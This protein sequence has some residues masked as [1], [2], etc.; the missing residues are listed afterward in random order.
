MK[1]LIIVATF[2][3]GLL[4]TSV[5]ATD[6]SI[7]GNV[8]ETL[9]GSDNY[10]LENKP[11]PSGPTGQTNTAGTLDFL[12]RTLTTN[13]F[14]D[15][16]YSY[17]KYFGPGAADTFPTW[18][19]PAHVNFNV[20]HTEKLTTY[21]AGASWTRSDA[22]VTELAQT[23]RTSTI[24]GSVSTYSANAAINHDLNRV[25]SLSWTAVASRTSFTDPTAFPFKDVTTVAAWN[26]ALSP[27]TKLSAFVS[28]DWFSEDDPAQS[29]RLF[30]KAMSTLS[31]SL[32]P[33]LTFNGRVGWGFV[34]SYQT[35][36][37]AIPSIPVGTVSFVPQVGAA[38]SILADIA[39]TYRLLKTTSVS[40]TAAEAI[41]P[42]FNGQLQKTDQIGL[43]LS[44]DVN[45]LS[46]LVLSASFSFIPATTGSSTFGAQSSA[47]DFFSASI[48]YGYQLAREWRT[49][50]SYTYRQRNDDTGIARSSLI[51]F[52]LSH[53]FT[54]LGNP[55]AINVA[56][57]EKARERAQQ[58]IGYVF[59]GFH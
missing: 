13:Y 33:R 28:F 16:Y 45:R 9:S 26:R 40:L 50:L 2:S 8:I 42:I 51:L 56:Q 34:N 48:S 4:A 31:T 5:H 59:P 55:T 14:L 3:V 19:T 44:H 41:V 25:D 49:S 24:H 37:G 46:N 27:T 38:N 10:F 6:L 30:W 52:T 36:P 47:S 29:Q 20:E 15:T 23:G 11:P 1:T 35:A 43:T 53:D 32:S 58:S 57:R 39:L 17:Y 18:G 21:L 12:A 7:K 54:L 22:A